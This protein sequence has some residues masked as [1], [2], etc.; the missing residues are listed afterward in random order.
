MKKK[1]AVKVPRKSAKQ[2]GPRL[3]HVDAGG[4]AQ[5]VD[6]SEKP[7]TQREAVAEVVVV[8]DEGTWALIAAKDVP[9]GDVLTAARLAG[10]MAAKRTPDLIPLCHPLQLSQVDLT[11]QA[12]PVEDGKVAL[13]ILAVAR[14]IGQ[15]GVEMEAM[16]AAAVSALTVYDMCKAV[17]RWMSVRELRLL[18]KRGGKS[19]TLRRPGY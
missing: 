13:C 11:F 14:C 1:V 16:T 4:N 9:K 19:G 3:S 8:M 18:E 6:I 15:T 12:A 2:A 7:G 10:I 17:D 5:M